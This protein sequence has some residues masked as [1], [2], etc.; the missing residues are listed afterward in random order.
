MPLWPS[1]RA[2]ARADIVAAIDNSTASIKNHANSTATAQLLLFD[3]G[4]R[5][6][7]SSLAND[8]ATLIDA[9]MDSSNHTTTEVR[10]ENGGGR[11]IPSHQS[12]VIDALCALCPSPCPA[13]PAST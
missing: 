7:L 11:Q 10:A 12:A 4:R 9:L 13:G 1:P 8:T 6:I 5:A 2:Q 3:Q